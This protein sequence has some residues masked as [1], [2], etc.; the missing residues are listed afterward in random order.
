MTVKKREGLKQSHRVD[1]ES[2]IVRVAMPSLTLRRL[3]E[4][5]REEVDRNLR[6]SAGFFG[7]G[8]SGGIE[9]GSGAS[10]PPGLGLDKEEKDGEEAEE[11]FEN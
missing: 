1:I 8:Q 9:G 4:I 2:T 6:W 3:R 11:Q 10:P 5:I 7:G